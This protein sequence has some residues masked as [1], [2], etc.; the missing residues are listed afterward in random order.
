MTLLEAYE[1]LGL[2]DPHDFA[3]DTL[4]KMKERYLLDDSSHHW[5]EIEAGRQTGRTTRRLVQACLRVLDGEKVAWISPTRALLKEHLLVLQRYLE[6]LGCSL[7]L[8]RL[9]LVDPIY[10]T[11]W[12]I[13]SESLRGIPEDLLK[14]AIYDHL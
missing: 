10:G 9:Q 1:K 12:V 8:V 11:P 14:R 4:R 7:K 3:A 2:A 6:R 5:E 13:G